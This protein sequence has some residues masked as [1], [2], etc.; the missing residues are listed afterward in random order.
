MNKVVKF[1]ARRCLPIFFLLCVYCQAASADDQDGEQFPDLTVRGLLDLNFMH[2]D[3][4][5][6]WLNE[7]LGKLSY[8]EG[9]GG[10]N[11]FNLNQ[12]AL[13]LQARLDWSWA[14]SVTAKY[15]ERQNAPIDLS[16]A[17]LLYKPVSTSGLRFSA[18]LG[19]FFPPV[20]L[21]NTGIAWTS[22][23][24]LSSST[25]NSWVGEE[26]KVFG[27]EAQ[28]NYQFQNSD[29]IG[30]FASGFGNNDT[31][32]VLL[33]WRGWSLDNYTAVLNDGYALPA[34][35]IQTYFP[36]QAGVTRPF[37]E[38]DDRPGFYAGFSIERPELGKFRAM[39][40]DN[41]A[42]PSIVKNGQYG[43]HTRFAS[44]G[45]K[46]DLPWESELIG[47]TMLGETQMGAMQAGLFAVDTSF[48]SG[49]LMLR[50]KLGPHRFYLLMEHHQ[51]NLEMSHIY[52]DRTARLLL[53]QPAAQDETLWQV[54][55]R[56]FF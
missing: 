34:I 18:R 20:S 41:R 3:G 33:A 4:A 26:L 30:V 8:T 51:I 7:G 46:L 2:P 42:N 38:I 35:G 47:Q 53:G 19:T 25:I 22:P 11:I 24:T 17:I 13:L 9:K 48:W 15:S 27:G 39:Y 16:E 37:T 50:K 32:G 5:N 28:L 12:A 31:S 56:L 49:T 55:Y 1:S 43:W 23:Y 6:S 29:R 52:S 40:Y 10:G 36:K 45:L 54:A 44:F 14:A 21:E